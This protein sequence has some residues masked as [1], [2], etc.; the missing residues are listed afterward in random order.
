MVKFVLEISEK[1]KKALQRASKEVKRV[2]KKAAGAFK[3]K[4]VKDK[5][6]KR[7]N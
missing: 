3:L 4:V 6:I 2:F 7:N 1:E 5:K